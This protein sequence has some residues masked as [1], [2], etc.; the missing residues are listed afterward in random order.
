M[1]SR[2]ET[3]G[4]LLAVL[5]TVVDSVELLHEDIAD[6]PE[7]TAGTGDIQS[8]PT[9]LAHVTVDHRTNHV[10]LRLKREAISALTITENVGDGG[11]AVVVEAGVALEVDGVEDLVDLAGRTGVEGGSGVDDGLTGAIGAEVEGTTIDFDVDHVNLPVELLVNLD[12]LNL[13]VVEVLIGSTKD[14]EGLALEVAG[15]VVE[16]E[17]VLGEEVLVDDVVEDGEV[18]GGGELGEGKTEDTVEL[19]V[20]EDIALG[21]GDLAEGLLLDVDGTKVEVVRAEEA[22]DTASTELDGH[23]DSLTLEGA[24]ET[25]LE[26]A[27]DLASRGNTGITHDPEVSRASIEDNLELLTRGADLNNTNILRMVDLGKGKLILLNNTMSAHLNIST[28]ETEL[29]EHSSSLLISQVEILLNTRTLLSLVHLKHI[30]D[31]LAR[32]SVGLTRHVNSREV[33][34]VLERLVVKMKLGEVLLL[35][36]LRTVKVLKGDPHT[37]RL[38]SIHV[39]RL[40]EAGIN[41]LIQC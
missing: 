31:S 6:D 7:G 39:L 11:E 25:G 10:P 23:F 34:L 30:K 22:A 12:V 14:D 28:L 35:L 15:R 4:G 8:H 26:V 16:G 41:S 33:V 5:A 18:T 19:D 2:G 21:T 37:G 3:D 17:H 27:V 1:V 38:V 24:R 32:H 36:G 9:L 13:A 40:E 20:H 29:R